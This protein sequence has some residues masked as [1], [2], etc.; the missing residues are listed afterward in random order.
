M[1]LSPLPQ[2]LIEFL[3]RPLPAVVAS[4]KPSG[5]LHTTATWYEMVDDRTTLVNMDARRARLTFLRLDAM[6]VRTSG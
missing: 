5:E 4:V 2:E 1:P 6:N 3:R